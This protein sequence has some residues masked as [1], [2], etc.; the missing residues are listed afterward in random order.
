[1]NHVRRVSLSL[2][3]TFYLLASSVFGIDTA[4]D[5]G[6]S[7]NHLWTSDQNWQYNAV[8]MAGD[9]A[10]VTWAQADE[11]T[12]PVIEDGMTVPATG[13]LSHIIV[14]WTSTPSG[15]NPTLTITGGNIASNW[16]NVAWSMSSNAHSQVF[17]SGG[18]LDLTSGDGHFGLGISPVGQ[19]AEF[20]QTGG[21]VDC[22]VAIFCWDSGPA[23]ADLLGG[24]FTIQNNLHM[25]QNGSVNIDGGTLTLNGVVTTR[26]LGAN[27]DIKS[28][29]FIINGDV[30]SELVNNWIPDGFITAKN[31][32]RQ[33]IYDYN[34]TNPGKTTIMADTTAGDSLFLFNN[35]P[36]SGKVGLWVLGVTDPSGTGDFPYLSV[37]YANG[38]WAF[39]NDVALNP[40][41]NIPLVGDINGDTITDVVAVGDNGLQTLFLGRNTGVDS[42]DVGNLLEPP[43]GSVGWPGNYVGANINAYRYYLGDV[44]GDG[45]DDAIIV[46]GAATGDG[47]S[48]FMQW[49]A[50]HSGARGLG[51]SRGKITWS[52]AGS[53]V[54]FAFIGDFNGDGRM[55]IGQRYGTEYEPTIPEG[56][57]EVATSSAT[58]LRDEILVEHVIQGFVSNQANY[59]ATLVGDINGDGLDD[60]VE[61]DDRNGN[62]NWVWVCGL[63]GASADPSG[64]AINAGGFSWASPFT[65]VATS[66]TATP[67]LADINGDGKDDL[68]LYEEYETGG[69]VWA[70]IQVAYTVGTD[71]FGSAYSEARW[72]NLTAEDLVGS[73]LLVGNAHKVREIATNPSPSNNQSG[74]LDDVTL[75]WDSGVYASSHDVYFGTDLN[76][77]VQASRPEG[78]VDRDGDVDIDD[79][80]AV[81]T[82]WT[83]QPVGLNPYTDVNG[84]GTV[85]L[86]DFAVVAEDWMMITSGV[87]KG[88][89]TA[90]TYDPGP[91]DLFGTYYWRVDEVDRS[92]VWRGAVWSFKPN[93]PSSLDRGHQLIL[94]HELQMQALV[95]PW[96]YPG[97]EE[98]DISRWDES[99]FN[100]ANIHEAP[101]AAALASEP[102]IPWARWM[103]WLHIDNPYLQAHELPYLST[104]V[105]LQVGDE[106]DLSDPTVVTK[107]ANAYSIWRTEYPDAICYTNQHGRVSQDDSVHR[108]YQA[109]AQPDMVNMHT[110]EFHDNNYVVGGSPTRMYKS[111]GRFR[112]FGMAGNDGTGATPIPYGHYFQTYRQ[113]V[114]RHMGVTEVS[115]GQFA[116]LAFGYKYSC[117]FFYNDPGDPTL[118]EELFDSD[119]DTQPNAKFYQA[120]ANNAQIQQLAPAMERLISRSGAMI[121]YVWFV[122]GQYDAGWPW[123]TEDIPVPEY[124]AQ[125][126]SGVDPYITNITATNLGGWNDG[127]RGDVVVGYFV[128][129]HESFDGPG[130][131]GELYFL[132]VNGLS[133][134]DATPGGV[135]QRIRLDFDFGG[136][137]I[138]S[139][140]R[141][142]RD[143]GI[144]DEMVLNHVGGSVYYIE[145]EIDGGEGDLFKFNTGAP[146]VGFYDGE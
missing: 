117:A 36:A 30:T 82:D 44:D 86:A 17:M 109:I 68:V 100:T 42:D 140:Q 46:R 10:H 56:T 58:G 103:S 14:G 136:S 131:T 81:A 15:I 61:V 80:Q 118:C 39:H 40:N 94:K 51:D 96:S 141:L 18:T 111:M 112:M 102:G 132:I 5:D 60:I 59:A 98:F 4:W 13:A 20:V 114:D 49:E 47:I 89:Q 99:N 76:E 124:C 116:G 138:T 97:G 48:L 55:D 38:G 139:I 105:A 16:L 34:R 11:L 129:L 65:L 92:D 135:R 21:T 2:V 85:N 120:A 1:M 145:L 79:V 41:P 26:E 50:H 144:V 19:T 69:E 57:I 127:L 90:N 77:V 63:T 62:G 53:A 9:V 128:P 115:L 106:R 107:M 32:T 29:A 78:D 52:V 22:L 31:G 126:H 73:V 87:Y 130:Y 25:W 84:D 113:D 54:N 75:S 6:A 7:G 23:H 88:N 45:Y 3:F 43:V 125:W 110:Y 33:V 66:L 71:L 8:P 95:F 122:P 108:N 104:L 37:S 91:L 134:V 146:F 119:G 137:G 64:Y 133:D 67:L 143:T 12:G 123:G 121:D 35:N 72:I 101:A 142:N 93:I 74:V 27:I 83:S 70:R 24:I 28:G